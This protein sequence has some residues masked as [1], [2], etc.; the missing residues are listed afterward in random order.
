MG[1]FKSSTRKWYIS[2]VMDLWEGIPELAKKVLK[3]LR[4]VLD[5]N[6]LDGEDRITLRNF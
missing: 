6:V 3:P 2:Y 1:R 5:I 4:E